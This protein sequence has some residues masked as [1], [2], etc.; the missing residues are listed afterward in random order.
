MLSALTR[1]RQICVD[2]STF[3]ENYDEMPAK[4]NVAMDLVIASLEG[5]HQVLVFSSFTRVLEHF[6]YYLEEKD[7]RA[8]YIS[9]ETPVH[10]GWKWRKSSTG[11]T[12]SGSCWCPS[13][14]AGPA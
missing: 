9:G 11:K 4:L 2:P 13:R 14:L 1:L 12:G 3:L 8:Y 5:N 10:C 6:R 7:I